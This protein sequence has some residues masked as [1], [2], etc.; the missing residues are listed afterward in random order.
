MN[1]FFEL[2]MEKFSALSYSNFQQKE[3]VIWLINSDIS[4]IPTSSNF[5]VINRETAN[6]TL[7]QLY[8]CI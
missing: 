1:R 2:R 4:D 8:Q 7:D 3:P 5:G 6:V